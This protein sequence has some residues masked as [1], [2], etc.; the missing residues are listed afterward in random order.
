MRPLQIAGLLSAE[1]RP[2]GSG[3]GQEAAARGKWV[4]LA[5]DLTLVALSS[6]GQNGTLT[7]E[8]GISKMVNDFNPQALGTE[9]G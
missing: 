1:A 3:C 6:K 7:A 9:E 2:D 8:M 5:E 4:S